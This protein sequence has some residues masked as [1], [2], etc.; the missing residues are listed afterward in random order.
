MGSLHTAHPVRSGVRAR[1]DT[2]VRLLLA[3]VAVGVAGA[4]AGTLERVEAWNRSDRYGVLLE[5]LVDV[6]ADT[7][8]TQLT[9]YQRLGRI[10]PAIKKAQILSAPRTGV[11]RL[12]TVI[13]LC[14]WKLC[15]KLDQVQ[16]MELSA[17]G[18]LLATLV[19]GRGS[20]RAGWAR[21]HIEPRG[22][23][24]FVRFDTE[25]EPGFFVP[26][27]IGPWLIARM[28]RREALITIDGLERL[29]RTPGPP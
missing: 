5:A 24:A 10:N 17:D 1:I 21:W 22:A 16:D 23:G 9:D 4:A 3:C 27:V 29:A 19:P 13:E 18:D 26:S 28:M 8:R 7:V 14:V 2:S 12:R 15:G 6:P 11:Q 25:L 20:F